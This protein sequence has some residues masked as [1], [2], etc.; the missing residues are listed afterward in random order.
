LL[1]WRSRHSDK[2]FG[3]NL[4][5]DGSL[6]LF[7]LLT[8][9]NLPDEML[10]DVMFFDEPELGLHPHAITL[11][12][13]MLKRLSQSRQVFIATQSPYMVD[14]FELENII[15]ADENHGAT[16]L[17]LLPREQY[18]AWLDDDYLLSEIWLKDPVGG[19]A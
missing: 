17:R 14:C 13:A 9:M 1:R 2:T 6:R 19:E 10:P 8:L 18:Q 5:S 16:R 11:V 7:C 15:V 3:P 4:T 12:A